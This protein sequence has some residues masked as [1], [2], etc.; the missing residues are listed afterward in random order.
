M[1]RRPQNG[2]T[3][4]G[5]A[6]NAHL[7]V[8]L[9]ANTGQVKPQGIQPGSTGQVLVTDSN[10]T[11]TWGDA[12]G[13]SSS[14]V[15][16]INI[17]LETEG[18]LDISKVSTHRTGELVSTGAGL[19]VLGYAG[20][21]ANVSANATATIVNTDNETVFVLYSGQNGAN[22]IG[23]MAWANTANVILPMYIPSGYKINIF[24]SGSGSA[25]VLYK[26]L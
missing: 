17:D 16:N 23:A 18:G 2:E 13:N 9:D 14:I 15:N 20:F 4:W 25:Y 5:T 24:V 19:L 3:N 12:Q 8:A 1:S 10:G 6:L 22:T 7:D 11:P 26:A 21:V